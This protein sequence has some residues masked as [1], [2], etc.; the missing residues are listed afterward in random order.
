M[1]LIEKANSAEREVLTAREYIVIVQAPTKATVFEAAE[2]IGQEIADKHQLFRWEN[3]LAK[4][5]FVYVRCVYDLVE[6]FNEDLMIDA[7][8]GEE[9]AFISYKITN[10]ADLERFI[11]ECRNLKK[12]AKL[13][14]ELKFHH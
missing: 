11:R 3:Q 13:D 12:D 5:V 8:G 2:Q 4:M 7:T 10:K 1:M 6:D 9:I 14:V